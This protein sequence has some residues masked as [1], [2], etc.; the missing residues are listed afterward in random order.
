MIFGFARNIHH[1]EVIARNR[2]QTHRI[3]R[4]TIRSPV[5]AL[6]RAMQQSGFGTETRKARAISCGPNFSPRA[7]AVRTPRTSDD[8]AALRDYPDSHKRAPANGR[9]NIPDAPPHTDPP[10]RSKPPSPPAIPYCRRPARPA[11]CHVDAIVPGYP[12]ITT[13][14]SDPTSMP[15]SS[16]LV[17]T[18][19]RISPDPQTLL[20]LPAFA[21]QITAAITAHRFRRNAAPCRRRLSDRSPV[22]R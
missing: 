17:A 14:S 9:T 16:A 5:P 4:I 13:A 12:A 3:G 18:T 1:H 8:S 21:R 10:A 15:S 19:A 11:R 7:T 22:S 2:P 6:A 20:D